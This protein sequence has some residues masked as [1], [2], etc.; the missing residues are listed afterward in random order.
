MRFRFLRWSGYTSLAI[1]GIWAV[2]LLGPTTEARV[3]SRS[4]RIVVLERSGMWFHRYSIVARPKNTAPAAAPEVDAGAVAEPTSELSNPQAAQAITSAGLHVTVT[5]TQ[6]DA[7]RTGATVRIHHLPVVTS[8]RW[9]VEESVLLG[10][11]RA[12]VAHVADL[13]LPKSVQPS[14]GSMSGLARVV[15]VHRVNVRSNAALF[16]RDQNAT[17]Q[18]DL[19]VVEFWAQR[20]RS[21]VRTADAVDARSIGD[22]GR[23]QVLQMHYEPRDPRRMRLDDGMRTHVN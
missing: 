17:K 19:I 8:V 2:I 6:H 3:E 5:E 4:D 14:L 11:F 1:F 22:L 21:V 20:L 9:L 13:R 12:L 16:K 18:I 15:S 23:G 7:L 10:A